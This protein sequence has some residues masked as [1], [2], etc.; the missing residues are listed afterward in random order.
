MHADERRPRLDLYALRE[1]KRWLG[2][3]ST[4]D[5]AKMTDVD[6]MRWFGVGQ[7]V[8]DDWHA[9]GA[10]VPV[11]ISLRFV[12]SLRNDTPDAMDV[13]SEIRLRHAREE[14]AMLRLQFRARQLDEKRDRKYGLLPSM[15]A[16]W[17]DV[18]VY[19][20]NNVDRPSIAAPLASTFTVT[21]PPDMVEV[22][23]PGNAF[24]TPC[25][26]AK[27][28]PAPIINPNSENSPGFI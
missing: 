22:T 9:H 26:Q 25:A 21:I 27:P 8:I 28:R 19:R 5:E 7:S 24:F 17:A 4:R 18:N 15:F 1:C 6:V 23:R 2:Y 12:R 13:R 14:A 11:H 20:F 10:P 16:D 3:A